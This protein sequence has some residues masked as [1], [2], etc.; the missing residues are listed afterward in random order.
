[1]ARECVCNLRYIEPNGL[2]NTLLSLPIPIQPDVH[3]AVDGHVIPANRG[4]REVSS[5]RPKQLQGLPKIVYSALIPRV[6]TVV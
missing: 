6:V 4:N 1:M 5:G 2:G 3:V